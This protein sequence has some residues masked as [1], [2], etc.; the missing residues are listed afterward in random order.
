MVILSKS[1]YEALTKRMDDLE[2]NLNRIEFISKNP[3]DYIRGMR[4]PVHGIDYVITSVEVVESNTGFHWEYIA[5][6]ILTGK[7]VLV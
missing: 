6:N 2:T 5:T 4:I 1:K 7:Q 3:P